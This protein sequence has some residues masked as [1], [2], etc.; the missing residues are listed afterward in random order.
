MLIQPLYSVAEGPTG[1]IP[2]SMLSTRGASFF[3]PKI[4]AEVEGILVRTVVHGEE[5]ANSFLFAS[6]PLKIPLPDPRCFAFQAAIS[7]KALPR[8]EWQP[9]PPSVGLFTAC[10]V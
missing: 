2:C 10:P 9:E 3:P 5:E 7:S 4:A 8:T 1:Q 6:S